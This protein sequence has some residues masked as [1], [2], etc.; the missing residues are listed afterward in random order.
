MTKE[1]LY[2]ISFHLIMHSG[3]AQSLAMQAI[4]DAKVGNFVEA[5][6]KLKDAEEEFRKAHH[7]QTSLISNEAG[8][9][10][11]DIPILLIHAQDHLMTSLTVKDLAKEMIELYERTSIKGVER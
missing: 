5:D 10:N 8:G 11:Y 2:D 9:E 1:E 7:F 4:G 6:Q 3:N